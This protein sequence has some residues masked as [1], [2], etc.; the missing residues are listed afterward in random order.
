M[1][2]VGLVKILSLRHRRDTNGCAQPEKKD[3]DW[4]AM[5]DWKIKTESEKYELRKQIFKT[6]EKPQDFFGSICDDGILGM[7]RSSSYLKEFYGTK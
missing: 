2:I 7:Q 1:N 5:Q 6:G 3:I 4:Q